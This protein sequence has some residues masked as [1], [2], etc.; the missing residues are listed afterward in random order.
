MTL[1]IVFSFLFTLMQLLFSLYDIGKV[2]K[3]GGNVDGKLYFN[4]RAD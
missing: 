3:Y 1:V 2:M 4:Q